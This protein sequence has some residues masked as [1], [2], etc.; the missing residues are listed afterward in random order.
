M[1]IEETISAARGRKEAWVGSWTAASVREELARGSTLVAIGKHDGRM[2]AFLS[3]R[4]PGPLW[5]IMLVV[6]LGHFRGQRL[7]G[8]LIDALFDYIDEVQSA[9]GALHDV[10]AEVI[11]VGLEVSA[12]NLSALRCYGN[13]GF[14]EQGRRKGYYTSSVSGPSDAV[15]M[16]LKLKRNAQPRLNQ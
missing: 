3:F 16:S 5:E 15:L 11:E 10:D 6:T 7:A 4:P 9:G 13:C 2:R 14:I 8:T 12:D 1:E